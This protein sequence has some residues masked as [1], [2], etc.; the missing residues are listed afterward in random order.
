MVDKP[1]G[2]TSHDV[3][4]VVRRAFRTRRV[5]HAGTLDPF[6]TGLLLV[7]IGRATRL[8]PFLSGLGKS[9]AGCLRLGTV[10]DTDDR[11]G[12]VVRESD[13]GSVAD[14]AI[15]E[16]MDALTGRYGQEPPRFSAKKVGGT[17]AHRLARRGA[18]VTLAAAN[19]EVR[20]FAMVA[21]RERDV[22]FVADVSSG[23]YVRSLARDLGERLGCGAHLTELRRLS[24]GGYRVE[25]AVGLDVV[26][27]GT[28][29]LLPMTAAVRALPA[30]VIDEDTRQRVRHGQAIPGA[31]GEP[32][33]VALVADGALVAVA[34]GAAGQ[35][36][37][38]VVLEG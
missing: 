3:V 32:G 4:A 17:R 22:E 37:P 26:R 11:T 23:T 1:A 14:A 20:R 34:V 38:R 13:A 7:L 31:A 9:Y 28:A 21:R 29:T 12:R 16:A 24:V 30:I 15:R 8:A 36:E 2:P 5:G 6:A 18:S 33:P 10:T 25:E 19:V 35:L 27:E